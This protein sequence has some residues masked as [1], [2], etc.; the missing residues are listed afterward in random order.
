[1]VGDHC[2]LSCLRPDNHLSCYNITSIDCVTDTLIIIPVTIEEV[3]E[4][5][6]EQDEPLAGEEEE[7]GA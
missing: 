2:A 7:K 3:E 6:N 1:M 5:T 4:R